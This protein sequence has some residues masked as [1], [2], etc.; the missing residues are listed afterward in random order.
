MTV[1]GVAADFECSW[2][3][4]AMAHA[5]ELQPFL[6]TVQQ[7]T[8]FDALELGASGDDHKGHTHPSCKANPQT[9]EQ[10][11]WDPVVASPVQRQR[12]GEL[13]LHAATAEELIDAFAA[14]G[15]HAGPALITLEPGAVYRLN[16]TLILGP[17]HSHT[18]MKPSTL[19]GAATIS[20]SKLLSGLTWAAVALPKAPKGVFKAS[21]VVMERG[22]AL[23]VNGLRAT[24]ARFPNA[25]PEFDQFP[26]GCES[27]NDLLIPL[28]ALWLRLR[29]RLSK[30]C[31]PAG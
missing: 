16:E 6:T 20:G 22:D 17:E 7:K 1:E 27:P 24:R 4:A 29:L 13:A 21:G 3:T 19:G 12:A 8:L 2:R 14:A 26:A 28:S 31:L 5:K 25:N 30:L 10:L 11:S 23:R 9:F 18:T 15:V